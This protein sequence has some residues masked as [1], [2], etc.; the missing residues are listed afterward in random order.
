MSWKIIV[1]TFF[2]ISSKPLDNA[3]KLA[4]MVEK[5]LEEYYKTDEKGLIKVTV[6]SKQWLCGNSA[7]SLTRAACAHQFSSIDLGITKMDLQVWFES[8]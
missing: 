5:K 7:A 6:N 3:S 8:P 1:K 2:S 4:Q